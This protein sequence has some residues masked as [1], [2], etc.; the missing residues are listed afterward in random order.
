MPN[1][2]KI[3]PKLLKWYDT[4][5]RKLP[6][7]VSPKESLNG[8]KADPYHIWLSE[9][10]LQQTTVKAVE[11]YFKS[12]ILR[13]PNIKNLAE[14][15]DEEIL[16]A[17]AGLGYY[18]R[19]HNLIQCA[20]MVV[21]V[22]KG[23]FPKEEK[24]LL[25]LPGIGPYTSAAIRSIGFNKKA[26]VVDGNVS[27]VISRLFAIN[28]PLESSQKTIQY[29]AGNL[30]PSTRFS[31]YAQALMDLGSQICIPRKPRCSD[32]PIKKVCKSCII[33][34]ETQIPYNTQK[35][36]RPIRYGYVFVTLNKDNNIILERRPEKGLLGGMLCF[37]SSEWKHSKDLEFSPPFNADWQ[38]VNEPVTHI[39][40]HFKLN[41]KIAYSF[42]NFTPKGYINK[43]LKKIDRKSLPSLMRKVFDI[44]ITHF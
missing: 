11:P 13:W 29:H 32:C 3:A 21:E 37:P 40:S 8:I 12:F 15:K 41:L 39:F 18:R 19:A 42:I 22:H 28:T 17:W 38:T 7:R 44:V 35:K 30:V 43:P 33:G 14:A 36:A 24:L 5:G 31:D 2:I 23:L 10:M 20:R 9:I 34:L 16:E 27:R 1:N 4:H 26:T 6:W 25:Q